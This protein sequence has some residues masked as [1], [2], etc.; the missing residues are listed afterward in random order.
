MKLKEIKELIEAQKIDL[1]KVLVDMTKDIEENTFKWTKKAIEDQMEIDKTL[2]Q[3]VEKLLDIKYGKE[4]SREKVYAMPNVKWQYIDDVMGAD[5]YKEAQ[6]FTDR[7]YNKSDSKI[8]E[9][10]KKDYDK[11]RKSLLTK[12]EKLQGNN[13]ILEITNITK[14]IDGKLGCYV[15]LDNNTRIEVKTISAGGWNIQKFHFRGTAKLLKR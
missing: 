6:Y 11:K 5:R 3:E 2:Y 10:I 1:E 13:K 12:I 14:E 7:G 15:I 9:V 8:K 4:H